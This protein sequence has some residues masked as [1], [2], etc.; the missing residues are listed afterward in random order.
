MIPPPHGRHARAARPLTRPRT[1]Q[2]P[3]AYRSRRTSAPPAGET[4][5]DPAHPPLPPRPDRH[6]VRP[7][8]RAWEQERSEKRDDRTRAGSGVL[9]TTSQR[10]S[11]GRP[12]ADLPGL[13]DLSDLADAVRRWQVFTGV[14]A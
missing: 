11:G 2:P 6:L 13:T 4:S 7:Y 8:Y 3:A 5:T 14:R 9:Q 12:H 10:P 1:S